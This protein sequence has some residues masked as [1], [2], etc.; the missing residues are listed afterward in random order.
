MADSCN[1]LFYPFSAGFENALFR[2]K[3]ISQ[4]YRMV[5]RNLWRIIGCVLFF[6]WFAHKVISKLQ[7]SASFVL[8]IVRVDGLQCALVRTR[9]AEEVS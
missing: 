7:V 8:H 4:D 5:G 6:Q 1:L 3:A 9:V 2:P